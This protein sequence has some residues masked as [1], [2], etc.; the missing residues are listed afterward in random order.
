M[1]ANEAHR[2]GLVFDA[3]RGNLETTAPFVVGANEGDWLE[4]GASGREPRPEACELFGAARAA[5][6][7]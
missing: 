2:P 6:G 1:S 4:D 3:A 7:R 5:R